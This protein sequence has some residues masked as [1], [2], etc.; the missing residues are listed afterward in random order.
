MEEL[1]S[2]IFRKKVNKT[3]HCCI[4]ATSEKCSSFHI[5]ISEEDFH[6]SSFGHMPTTG[7]VYGQEDGVVWLT[8]PRQLLRWQQ[9]EWQARTGWSEERIVQRKW[10]NLIWRWKNRSNIH[11]WWRVDPSLW[12]VCPSLDVL[13][14]PSEQQGKLCFVGKNVKWKHI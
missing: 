11:F 14:I 7:P 3:Q 8:R 5:N 6:W 4:W 9:Y 10:G 12:Q 13:T 2:F 1:H